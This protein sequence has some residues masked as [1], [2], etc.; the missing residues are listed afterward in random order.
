MEN[1]TMEKPG[2]LL[3]LLF[4]VLIL[5]LHGVY[6]FADFE[7][8]IFIKL[9]TIV[10]NTG[11]FEFFFKPHLL[12]LA[13]ALIYALGTKGMKSDSITIGRTLLYLVV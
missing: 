7:H 12:A 5:I 13:F 4:S 6:Q 2:L 11:L 1:D 3:A 8:P 9:W 10:I